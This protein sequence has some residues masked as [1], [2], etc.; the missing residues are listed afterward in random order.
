MNILIRL[1]QISGWC[2]NLHSWIMKL[3]VK[4]IG[5]WQIKLLVLVQRGFQITLKNTSCIMKVNWKQ[6]LYFEIWNKRLTSFN[7]CQTFF[8]KKYITNS[9]SRN[10]FHNIVIYQK[11]LNKIFLVGSNA[12]LANVNL[13]LNTA[14]FFFFFCKV[15]VFLRI[16]LNNIG[17]VGNLLLPWHNWNCYKHY[18]YVIDYIHLTTGL[19]ENNTKYMYLIYIFEHDEMQLYIKCSHEVE[20]HILHCWTRIQ[21]NRNVYYMQQ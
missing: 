9:G 19:Q 20:I 6:L 16:N 3:I 15:S 17:R 7:I 11:T 21:I 1:E 18:K 5:M 12:L 4:Y 8:I 2:G 10:T 13:N 14:C